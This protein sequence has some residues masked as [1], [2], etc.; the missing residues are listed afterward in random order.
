MHLCYLWHC[1]RELLWKL[2]FRNKRLP[3]EY[4][5]RKSCDDEFGPISPK[6]TGWKYESFWK[7][8]EMFVRKGKKRYE[9]SSCWGLCTLPIQRWMF[10]T[11]CWLGELVASRSVLR[12][13]CLPLSKI[14]VW[15]ISK[16]SIF[17]YFVLFPRWHNWLQWA[18]GNWIHKFKKITTINNNNHIYMVT[19]PFAKTFVRE[20]LPI[21]VMV[22]TIIMVITQTSLES[23]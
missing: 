21:I 19:F 16:W 6:H 8:K 15:E 1:K 23:F 4:C 5:R 12:I 20:L 11:L 9:Y 22:K 13:I 7:A 10:R 3:E 18:G 17:F 2:W 14:I